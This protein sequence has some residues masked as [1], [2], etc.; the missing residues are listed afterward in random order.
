MLWVWKNGDILHHDSTS[1]PPLRASVSRRLPSE[2]T[3]GFGKNGA[4]NKW[5]KK[6]PW[7]QPYDFLWHLLKNHVH[8]PFIFHINILFDISYR[9]IHIH[10]W[11]WL[12]IIQKYHICRNCFLKYIQIHQG[13]HHLMILQPS[14]KAFSKMSSYFLPWDNVVKTF[15]LNLS[16]LLV[17]DF[18][19]PNVGY[20]LVPWRVRFIKPRVCSWTTGLT[21]GKG[22]SINQCQVIQAMTFFIP[23]PWTPKP[24]KNAGFKPPIWGF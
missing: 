22:P 24:W 15:P 8:T 18:A 10:I 21:L 7:K 1:N 2:K 23:Y 11:M 14:G 19:F 12:K 9:Y 20:G 3:L 17:D 5:T 13:E 16:T 6:N 4:H